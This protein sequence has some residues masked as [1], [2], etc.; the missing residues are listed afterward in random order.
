MVW[1]HRARRPRSLTRI[2]R[3]RFGPADC[4]RRR[5]PPLARLRRRVSAE[6]VV[7]LP[8]TLSAG[9]RGLEEQFARVADYEA[10]TS[11]AEAKTGDSRAAKAAARAE[12][13]TTQRRTK[14]SPR[15]GAV[16]L[17]QEI[18]GHATPPLLAEKIATSAGSSKGCRSQRS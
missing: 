18:G 1:R 15:G 10:A 14:P 5:R 8:D 12:A 7:S 9:V 13:C 4:F 17:P 16:G 6:A 11:D 3:G 2:S